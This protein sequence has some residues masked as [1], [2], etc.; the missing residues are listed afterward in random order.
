MGDS[1]KNVLE[2]GC[3][4]GTTALGIALRHAPDRLVAIEIQ[5]H[6]LARTLPLAR[7]QLGIESLP[8]NL[9]FVE[10]TPGQRLRELGTFDFVYSWSVFEHVHQDLIQPCLENIFDVLRPG[11]LMFLQT[12]PLYY[13]AFGSHFEPWIPTPWAHLSMQEDKFREK[14]RLATIDNEALHKELTDVYNTLN[15]AT[16]AQLLEAARA[17]GFEIIR[18]HRTYDDYPIPDV[19]KNIYQEQVLRTQQLVF[20]ARKPE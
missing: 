3:G 17:V 15:R 13:S 19:L 4:E 11:G 1:R 2:F 12:T 10:V 8:A 18:E 20:M 14:L 5:A 9:E 6:E 7:E 16:D